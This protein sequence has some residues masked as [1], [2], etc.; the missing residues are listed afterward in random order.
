MIPRAAGDMSRVMTSQAAEHQASV[1]K[2]VLTQVDSLAGL[3]GAHP[4]ALREI[5]R[6]GRATDP[7]ELGASPRGRMLAIMPGSN[8]FLLTRPL[9]RAMATDY[10]PWRGVVFDHGGNSGVNVVFGK[11]AFRFQ[12]EVGPSALDGRPALILDYGAAAHQN[13][14]P[15]RSIRDELR[16]VGNGIAIGPTLSPKAGG[17]PRV[18]AWFGLEIARD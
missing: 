11:Q 16:T 14:W 17:E 2:R 1:G 7:A 12:V 9:V 15:L 8:V 4:D 6:S 3:V 5:F 10:N 18:R 13:P